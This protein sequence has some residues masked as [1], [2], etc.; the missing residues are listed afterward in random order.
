MDAYAARKAWEHTVERG[1][2]PVGEPRLRA[3]MLDEGEEVHLQLL[4]KL[5]SDRSSRWS[6]GGR[7]TLA[8]SPDNPEWVKKAVA[9]RYYYQNEKIGQPISHTDTLPWSRT[10]DRMVVY[11]GKLAAVVADNGVLA[12]LLVAQRPPRYAVDVACN[13][14]RRPARTENE[15]ETLRAAE[16][17]ELLPARGKE[18]VLEMKLDDL[19]GR[20]GKPARNTGKAFG[21]GCIADYWTER[22]ELK[23]LLKRARYDVKRAVA[24]HA[25]DR[26]VTNDDWE[27]SDIPVF[28]KSPKS[29]KAARRAKKKPA[30]ETSPTRSA[31]AFE[32]YAASIRAEVQAAVQAE[33]IKMGR[34]PVPE[35]ERVPESLVMREIGRRWRAMGAGDKAPFVAQAKAAHGEKL[36]AAM[37]EGA[38]ATSP[39]KPDDIAARAA[40]RNAVER[41]D[42]AAVSAILARGVGVDVKN[43]NGETALMWAAAKGSAKAME[44]LL[45]EIGAIRQGRRVPAA[46][47]IINCPENCN[48]IYSL[49]RRQDTG[50]KG[51]IFVRKTKQAR[52]LF[53]SAHGEWYVSG[54]RKSAFARKPGG[55]AVLAVGGQAEGH[56]PLLPT[57]SRCAGRWR[58]YDSSTEQ[59]EAC[60]DMACMA[61]ECIDA[62]AT[63]GKLKGKTALMLAAACED[64]EASAAAAQALIYGGASTEVKDTLEGMTALSYAA[65]EGNAATAKIILETETETL[66]ATEKK[67]G[68]TA[69][70]LAAKQGHAA[71]CRVLLQGGADIDATSA[72]GATGGATALMIAAQFGHED[73]IALL[74]AALGEGEGEGEVEGE[75]EE[76]AAPLVARPTRI[77]RQAAHTAA[78]VSAYAKASTGA[79]ER[80]QM[81]E[82]DVDAGRVAPGGRPGKNP[83][84]K[85]PPDERKQR[86]GAK[87]RLEKLLGPAPPRAFPCTVAGC[88]KTFYDARQLKQHAR[89][90]SAARVAQRAAKLA[91]VR[92]KKKEAEKFEVAAHAAKAETPQGAKV[93]A[94]TIKKSRGGSRRRPNRIQQPLMK[95]VPVLGWD[96]NPTTLS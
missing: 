12:T 84:K 56:G 33:M 81:A 37:A 69:L 67:D 50:A 8:L 93:P 59:Y 41:D 49:M 73:V 14:L 3:K 58:V 66:E 9:L 96:P 86:G 47:E 60:G 91:A 30:T 20:L 19:R 51:P 46:I 23:A 18:T 44:A 61:V 52:Y 26:R 4:P 29:P 74:K 21:E 76:A 16:Y 72:R 70:M 15:N 83:G 82:N 90:C 48:G 39:V 28:R 2:R 13:L 63:S 53:P 22:G 7:T 54:N 25:H 89:T 10:S 35:I 79:R 24:L 55:F 87:V 32:V 34:E 92:K 80:A 31:S 42:A 43:T 95:W 6:P 64:P 11:R 94:R 88:G 62:T 65:M 5:P 45:K 1:W 27:T 36:I 75:V 78:M 40:L 71:V 77:G 85:R 38:A 57:A 68:Y 17:V